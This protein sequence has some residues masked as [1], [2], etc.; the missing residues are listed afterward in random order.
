MFGVLLNGAE[1]HLLDLNDSLAPL[2]AWLEQSRIPISTMPVSMLRSVCLAARKSG[3]G[4]DLRFLSVSG[5]ALLGSDVEPFRKVFR[6]SSVLQN[7]MPATEPRT[8][9]Q[10]FVPR[11]GPA[12]AATP[13]GWPVNGKQVGVRDAEGSPVPDGE[14]GEIVV[15]SRYLA[16]GYANDAALTT[17]AFVPGED[18]TVVYRTG[19]YGRFSGDGSLLFLGRRDRRVKVRGYRVE[20]GAIEAALQKLPSVQQAVGVAREDAPGEVRL[21]AHVVPKA[22][23]AVTAEQL[24]GLLRA[25][26]PE[27]MVPSEFAVPDALPLTANRKVDRARLPA[28]TSDS[29]GALLRIWSEVLGKPSL[30]PHDD[31]YDLGGGSLSALR[32]LVLIQE[33]VPCDLQ[34]ASLRE[35]PTVEQLARLIDATREARVARRRLVVFNASGS[36]APIFFVHPIGGSAQG[37]LHL[38]LN[39]GPDQP[40]YGLSCRTPAASA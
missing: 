8:Y 32:L 19:D 4:P 26:L 11:N 12:A 30:S 33:H 5:W 35:H 37:Y 27:Y 38:A 18:G 7:A 17:Q 23:A 16:S 10:Y 14:E 36:R 13:I 21:I 15:R 6:L 24:R 29:V 3:V 40:S 39:L 2:A 20:L 22:G 31:F 1:L 28:V 34:P 25:E 9:A